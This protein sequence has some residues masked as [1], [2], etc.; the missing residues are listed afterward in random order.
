M[1][2]WRFTSPSDS[3][4]PRP[5]RRILASLRL[6]LVPVDGDPGRVRRSA[7]PEPEVGTAAAH[8]TRDELPHA[9]PGTGPAHPPLSIHARNAVEEWI[10]AAILYGPPR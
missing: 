2:A 7:R 4:R 1:L 3:S 10:P 8:G 9:R 5:W 6:S